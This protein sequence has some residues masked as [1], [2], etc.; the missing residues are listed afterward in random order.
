VTLNCHMN[1][2][3]SHVDCRTS[4]MSCVHVAVAATLGGYQGCKL[5]SLTLFWLSSIPTNKQTN[6]LGFIPTNNLG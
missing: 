5:H 2:S 3:L 6:N 1:M 4:H